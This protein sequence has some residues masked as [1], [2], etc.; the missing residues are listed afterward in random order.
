[1][2][3]DGPKDGQ[4]GGR[5]DGPEVELPEAILKEARRFHEPPAVPR[6]E[7]WARIQAARQDRPS[8]RPPVRPSTRPVR[9]SSVR[10]PF[11]LPAWLGIAALLA[12]GIGIGRWSAGPESPAPQSA[13]AAPADQPGTNVAVS[14]ATTEHLSRTEAFL[15]AV[16][17]G[18]RGPAFAVQARDLLLTTRMLL[19]TRAVTDPRTR[20]LLQDLELILVQIAQAGAGNGEEIDL[21]NDALQ[22]REV[23]PRLRKEL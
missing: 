9:R 4:T 15:T 12:L 22:Q 7:I 2:T 18:E 21:L 10:P 20:G 13:V 6:E 16:R 14:L 3:E 8:A 11:R 23:L 19:D 5:A 1:M 17:V